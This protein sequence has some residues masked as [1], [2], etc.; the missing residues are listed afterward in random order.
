MDNYTKLMISDFENARQFFVRNES[1]IKNLESRIDI[2]KGLEEFNTLKYIIEDIVFYFD[3]L[4]LYKFSCDQLKGTSNNFFNIT[5]FTRA[6]LETTF[7]IMSKFRDIIKKF[8]NVTDIMNKFK[9]I[10]DDLGNNKE[11]RNVLE[12][13][14]DPYYMGEYKNIQIEFSLE[15]QLNFLVSVVE[16][17]ELLQLKNITLNNIVLT[18]DYEPMNEEKIKE[19][20]VSVNDMHKQLF[21]HACELSYRVENNYRKMEEVM[22]RL[23]M[24]GNDR[25]YVAQQLKKQV[26]SDDEKN[27]MDLCFKL[28]ELNKS[29]IYIFNPTIDGLQ[30]MEKHQAYFSRLAINKCY[31]ICDKLGLYISMENPSIFE[32]TYFKSVCKKLEERRSD[33]RDVEVKMIQLYHSNDYEV[34]SKTRNFIEHKKGLVNYELYS[35]I[36]SS[37]IINTYKE[38][39]TIVYSI[40]KQYFLENNIKLSDRSYLET[41]SKSTISKL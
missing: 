36:I 18:L 4:C 26:T 3:T 20:A 16:L 10:N 22:L 34:L 11:F 21:Q 32:N 6:N 25:K 8:Q 27:V 2:I 33:L 1:K 5:T 39:N 29:I 13:A 24:Q 38:L 9:K 7:I 28:F 14:L 41:L 40:A 35:E 17:T 31:Q 12:H 30:L 37:A 15:K 23:L 19:I